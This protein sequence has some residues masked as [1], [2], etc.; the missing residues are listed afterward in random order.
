MIAVGDIACL[1]G[2]TVTTKTCKQRATAKLAAAENPDYVIALGDEQY[3]SGA[4]SDFNS[5]Y[6][7]SWGRFKSITKPAP[8][9]HEYRTSNA[10]GYYRYFENQIP[11]QAE[12][13]AY[14]LGT[15][16]AYSLNSNCTK[17]DCA[18]QADWFRNDLKDH[19]YRCTLMYMHSPRYSSGG[20]HGSDTSAPIKDLWSIAYNHHLDVALAAHDHGYERFWRQDAY[21]HRKADGI[22]SYVSGAG[23]KSLYQWGNIQQGSQARNNNAFGLLSLTL[24]KGVWAWEYKTTSGNTFD[25]GSSSC[26]GP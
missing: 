26:V 5:S 20:E 1:P 24:G 14:N 11:S 13:Y 17:I 23:G 9:N 19:A 4:L 22:L 18:T 3:D 21:G 6:D 15:W 25:A 16:R 8:G 10:S 12:Y 2:E 7:A